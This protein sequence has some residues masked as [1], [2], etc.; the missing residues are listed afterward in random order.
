MSTETMMATTSTTAAKPHIVAE[1][2][3]LKRSYEIRRGMFKAPAL[4]QAVTGVSFKVEAGKTL[5]VVGESG[6]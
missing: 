3:N 4:L 5:A 2:H 1:A 6:C